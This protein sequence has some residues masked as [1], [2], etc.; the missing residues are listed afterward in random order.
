M[1][2]KLNNKY[3]LHIKEIFNL[4]TILKI[5]EAY[6]YNYDKFENYYKNIVNNLLQQTVTLYNND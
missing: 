5:Q 4:R 1:N 6:K 3:Y 2:E